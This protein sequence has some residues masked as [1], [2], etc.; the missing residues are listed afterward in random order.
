MPAPT[1]RCRLC[2]QP[3]LFGLVVASKRRLPIDPTRYAD[4]DERANVAVAGDHLGSTYVRVISKAE[5]LRAN[6]RRAMPHFAT[7]PALLAQR[8]RRRQDDQPAPV[9]LRLVPDTA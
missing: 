7:C 1:T 5:P 4:D 6:E 9:R 2:S 8:E 3:I